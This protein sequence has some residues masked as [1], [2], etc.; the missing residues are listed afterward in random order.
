MTNLQNAILE[1]CNEN[2]ITSH[3]ANALLE[4]CYYREP[5]LGINRNTKEILQYEIEQICR[6]AKAS[7]FG[8]GV[9]YTDLKSEYP[10]DPSQLIMV[11][12]LRARAALYLGIVNTKKNTVDLALIDTD[13]VYAK[14]KNSMNKPFG[15]AII[16]ILRTCEDIIPTDPHRKYD[17]YAFVGSVDNITTMRAM[18][19]C[20]DKPNMKSQTMELAGVPLD[21]LFLEK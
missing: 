2:I 9:Q 16:D 10:I 21:E 17:G 3:E 11:N 15:K 4:G 19:H 12:N 1:A 13:Y 5:L 7:Y 8:I 18:M 20:I 14:D 6:L